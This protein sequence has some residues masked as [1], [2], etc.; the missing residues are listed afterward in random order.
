M[1]I[2][3]KFIFYIIYKFKKYKIIINYYKSYINAL[4]LLCKRE[5][6]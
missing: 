3:N 4:A 5:L 2:N 6:H 1:K